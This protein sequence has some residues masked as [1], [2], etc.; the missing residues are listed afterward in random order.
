MKNTL[1]HPTDIRLDN[2][3]EFVELINSGTWKSIAY[4]SM[5]KGA[6][7]GNHYHKKTDVF[8]FLVSGRVLVYMQEVGSSIKKTIPLSS[9]QGIIIARGT[10]HAIQYLD[11]GTFVWAKSQSFDRKKQDMYEYILIEGKN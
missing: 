9:K 4:G 8:F 11:D 2:R 3:G 1:L 10:A 5:K 6:V 7:M